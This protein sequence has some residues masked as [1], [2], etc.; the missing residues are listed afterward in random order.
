MLLAENRQVHRES[1]QRY[2]NPRAGTCGQ[3]WPDRTADAT[4]WHSGDDGAVKSGRHRRQSPR[5]PIAPNLI[6]RDL[7]AAAPNR[8]WLADIIY[9]P[10]AE[11]WLYL[12]AIMDLF[13]RKILGW[14]MRDHMR[15]ALVSSAL[16]MALRQ[17]RPGAGDTSFRSRRAVRFTRIS[18]SPCR[19]QH[20]RIDEPTADCF[21]NALM[22]SFFHTLA[23]E[24]VH[25]RL[26]RT[27]TEA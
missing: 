25:H 6:A 1:R 23:T 12:A 24:F 4:E 19:G 11:G 5:L 8:V 3:L 22:E 16:T 2:G 27:R 18:R 26:Y 20:H 13:S 15:V 10:T 17:E 14:A 21:D 9:I 7:F